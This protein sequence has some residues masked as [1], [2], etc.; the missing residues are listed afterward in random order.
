MRRRVPVKSVGLAAGLMMAIAAVVAASSA[1]ALTVTAKTSSAGQPTTGQDYL[2]CGTWTQSMP[3]TSGQSSEQHFMASAMGNQY[4]YTPGTGENCENL[5]GASSSGMFMWTTSH[6]HAN[7]SATNERGT[8]H[9][10]FMLT[11]TTQAGRFNG[12]ITDYD[13]NGSGGGDP[14][15]CGDGRNVYYSSGRNFDPSCPGTPN[16]PG[17]FNT[18]GG[19]STGQHYRGEYGTLIYQDNSNMNCQDNGGNGP[20]CF[21]TIVKGQQ[22]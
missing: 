10:T 16:A 7:T 11:N 18:Q 1:S 9:G 17:N 19:A 21:Q 6:A 5:N 13:V 20:F 15:S 8:E 2:L 12:R 4:P 14:N 3:T 22:N